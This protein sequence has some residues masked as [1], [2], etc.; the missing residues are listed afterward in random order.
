LWA[1]GIGLFDSGT[2]AIDAIIAIKCLCV[3]ILLRFCCCFNRSPVSASHPAAILDCSLWESPL[4]FRSSG[5]VVMPSSSIYR[6]SPV[7][8]RYSCSRCIAV[9]CLWG[10]SPLLII[11]WLCCLAF[12]VVL[13]QLM[14]A[15]DHPFWPAMLRPPN[16]PRL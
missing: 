9:S 5:A 7:L 15:T 2:P 6:Q 13:F 10:R 14:P 12:N 11:P 16:L 4:F 1:V 3:S 8:A